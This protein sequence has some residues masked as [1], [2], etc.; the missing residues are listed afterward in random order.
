MLRFG[1]SAQDGLSVTL[2]T[3]GPH[4]PKPELSHRADFLQPGE[5]FPFVGFSACHFNTHLFK[6]LFPPACPHPH[7]SHCQT[8][9]PK[10]K[11]ASEFSSVRRPRPSKTSAFEACAVPLAGNG[12]AP[13]CLLQEFIPR[14]APGGVG[15]HQGAHA[16]V[17]ATRSPASAGHACRAV[18][19]YGW[20]G[21]GHGIRWDF[22]SPSKTCMF[23]PQHTTHTHTESSSGVI[24]LFFGT[25][26]RGQACA[27]S[28][29]SSNT[30]G[31]MAFALWWGRR[32]VGKQGNGLA[33][34]LTPC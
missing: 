29:L 11:I 1:A 8:P 22:F 25:F 34:P 3:L 20:G 18:W 12:A 24:A 14:S 26:T 9:L 7:L 23:P 30:G 28:W 13:L 16:A 19:R 15:A 21:C 31:I 33:K 6:C 10:T 2:L 4:P 17:R 27:P 32:G 5:C